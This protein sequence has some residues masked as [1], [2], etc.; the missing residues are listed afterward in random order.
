MVVAVEPASRR[1]GCPLVV[2]ELV[3]TLA[4]QAF[5]PSAGVGELAPDSPSTVHRSRSRVEDAIYFVAGLDADF[6][7]MLRQAGDPG[8]YRRETRC[9]KL[10]ES[11]RPM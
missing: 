2:I 9:Q 10:S 7:Q 11:S 6:M 4:V 5:S 3:G 1:R 8:A